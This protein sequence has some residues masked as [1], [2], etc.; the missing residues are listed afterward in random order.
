M[1]NA[2][3]DQSFSRKEG[4]ISSKLA[5]N[6]PAYKHVLAP[7]LRSETMWHKVT[8]G[9]PSSSR[10]SALPKSEFGKWERHREG[11]G[12][13]AEVVGHMSGDVSGCGED[14][15]PLDAAPTRQRG[16]TSVC[17]QLSF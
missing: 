2:Q 4:A 16:V 12:G 5:I 13:N 15:R 14:E 9:Q 3:S 1:C 10:P 7:L 11:D 8:S 17:N 6:G